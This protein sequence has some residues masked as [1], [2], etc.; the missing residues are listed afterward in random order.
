MAGVKEELGIHRVGS[1]INTN[2]LI[3]SPP[4]TGKTPFIGTS[5]RGLI[6]DCDHGETSLALRKSNVDVV[7]VEDHGKLFEILDFAEHSNHDYKWFWWDSLTL[8]QEKGLEDIMAD[9][10][11]GSKAMGR[12]PKAHRDIDLP[13]RGEYKLNYGRIIRFVRHMSALPVNFGI[14][15]HVMYHDNSE[16]HVPLIAG[17]GKSGPIWMKVCGY[18]GVVGYLRKVKLKPEKEGGKPKVVWKLH[19][20]GSFKDYYGKSWFDE[21]GTLTEPTVP[22]IDAIVEKATARTKSKKT[23]RKKTTSRKGTAR[24]TTTGRQRRRTR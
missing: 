2:M 3:F 22:K 7:Q 5:E 13:D 6:L 12:A 21:I 10:I 23:S 1:R 17:E 24:R 8:F 4:G 9:V 18:M 14:T 16:M 15:A 20:D 11:A 19:C